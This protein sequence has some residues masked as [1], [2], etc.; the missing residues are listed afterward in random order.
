MTEEFPQ[1]EFDYD[2]IPPEEQRCG[3]IA[4][5]GAPNAGKSTLIN[6]MVGA[7]VSIVS[8]KVQTTRTRVLGIAMAQA[9]QIVFIDTPGIFE[10]KRRLERAMVAAAWTG[11]DEADRV[12]LVV[13]AHRGFDDDSRRIVERLR[14]YRRPAVLVLNKVDLVKRERLLALAAE[15]TQAGSF[16]QT[17]MISAAKG[18][19]VADVLGYLAGSVPQGVWHFPPDQLS[20]LPQRMLASEITRE[21]LFLQLHEE[22]PY[23]V[24]V[25]TEQWEEREDGSARIDQTI[26]VLRESQKP[27]VLGKGGQQ[28]KRIGAMAR[29]ELEELFERRIHLFLYVKVRENWTDDPHRYREMGLDFNA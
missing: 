2:S 12:M 5:V 25:E 23:S 13:D 19:H 14:E 10:P 15:I 20:D 11:A 8:P 17:F 7:K 9:A 29:K 4:V 22:L 16:E 3:F 6:A 18:D 1:D 28:I 27:I 21:K 26:Y 24:T